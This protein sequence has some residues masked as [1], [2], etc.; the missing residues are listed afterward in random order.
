MKANL[1]KGELIVDKMNLTGELMEKARLARDEKEL[2]EIA[3]AN[4]IDL[5]DDQARNYFNKLSL[6]RGKL[7]DEELENVSGGSQ[8]Q[9]SDDDEK[10]CVKCGSHELEK[11]EHK[12]IWAGS[13]YEY[14]C[15]I[16]GHDNW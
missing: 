14:R 2:C 16:C 9:C 1:K 13:R 11:I 4:G 5:T 8:G 10:V 6:K 12:Y 15:K 7:A 3:K